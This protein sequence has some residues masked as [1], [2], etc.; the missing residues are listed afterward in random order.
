MATQFKFWQGKVKWC[1]PHV[2]NPWGKYT[3]TLYPNPE[4]LEEIRELQGEGL[5][6]IIKKDEDGYY[7]TFSRPGQKTYQSAD[8]I[9]QT[10]G[11]SPP[12]VLDK[13]GTTPLR[14]V[15]IGNGSDA[16][17]KIEIYEHKTPG[18]GKAKAARWSSIRVDNLV[19]FDGKHDFDPATAKLVRG[20]AEQPQQE[21]IF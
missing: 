2:L 10:R 15:N 16:T 3:T 7:V 13:D 17:L 6:N 21:E 18:G 19:P 5:K 8:G 1:R 14:D 11:F 12:E 4:H 20:Q 9:P